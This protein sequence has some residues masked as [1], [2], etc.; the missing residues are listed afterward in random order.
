MGVTDNLSWHEKLLLHRSPLTKVRYAKTV[1]TVVLRRLRTDLD[2]MQHLFIAVTCGDTEKTGCVGLRGRSSIRISGRDMPI[3]HAVVRSFRGPKLKNLLPMETCC[4]EE[5]EICINPYHYYE[6]APERCPRID[7]GTLC[8][9]YG[10][11]NRP[12]KFADISFFK[13]P[14]K[15]EDQ[16]Y[17][18][19]FAFCDRKDLEKT[20]FLKHHRICSQ[21]FRTDDIIWTGLTPRLSLSAV[22]TERPGSSNPTKIIQPPRRLL[23]RL[24]ENG[25]H[26]FFSSKFFMKLKSAECDPV[27]NE[28]GF[29][30]LQRS[31][32]D[33]LLGKISVT[34]STPETVHHDTVLVRILP[35]AAPAFFINGVLVGNELKDYIGNETVSN[36]RSLKKLLTFRI[37]DRN[38]VIQHQC[39]VI[40]KQCDELMA[41]LS[42]DPACANYDIEAHSDP[43]EEGNE[44]DDTEVFLHNQQISSVAK[45][46]KELIVSA[47]KK[48]KQRRYSPWI[49][50]MCA[51]AKNLSAACYDFFRRVLG[52]ALPHSRTLRDHTASYDIDDGEDVEHM[53][54]LGEFCETI[55]DAYRDVNL[56]C[57]VT[58]QTQQIEYVNGRV[59]GVAENQEEV[60]PAK[61]VL[62]FIIQSIVG[63]VR[64]IVSYHFV[65]NLKGK[66]LAKILL[67]NLR[68]LAM[69]TKFR[70]RGLCSDHGAENV[71][72]RS[73]L[74]VQENVFPWKFPHPYLENEMVIIILDISHLLKR[75]WAN[76]LRA[77]NNGKLFFGDWIFDISLLQ[78]LF[79][80]E[81]CSPVKYA[82]DI[83]RKLLWPNTFEKMSTRTAEGLFSDRTVGCLT[84]LVS[85]TPFHPLLVRMAEVRGEEVTS[86]KFGL[87]IILNFIHY[88]RGFY[89]PLTT[90][91]IQQAHRFKQPLFEVITLENIDRK[92]AEMLDSL[93]GI[94]PHPQCI[95]ESLPRQTWTGLHATIHGIKE[96]SRVALER[97]AEYILPRKQCS[98]AI[99]E[100][101]A[102][103]K[104]GTTKLTAGKVRQNISN[105]EAYQ[106]L[107]ESPN[108]GSR[109]K[110]RKTMISISDAPFPKRRKKSNHQLRD[111]CFSNSEESKLLIGSEEITLEEKNMLLEQLIAKDSH[112]WICTGMLDIIHSTWESL[113]HQTEKCDRA[114]IFG[115]A[116]ADATAAL[117]RTADRNSNCE[118]CRGQ[119][120][121]IFSSSSDLPGA[122]YIGARS[123]AELSGLS[124]PRKATF[125][126]CKSAYNLFMKAVEFPEFIKSKSQ[127][128]VILKLMLIKMSLSNFHPLSDLCSCNSYVEVEYIL[129]RKT[130]N[131]LLKNYVKNKRDD[132]FDLKFG[133]KRPEKMSEQPAK[134]AKLKF[135]NTVAVCHGGDTWWLG[136]IQDIGGDHAF[137]HSDS[138]IAEA[139]WIQ[140]QDVWQLPS[141]WD[142][143]L[144]YRGVLEEDFNVF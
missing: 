120:V 40:G 101:N 73:V 29:T 34:A 59:T 25:Q 134:L 9:V 122:S 133:K 61:N 85:Q 8:V 81:R 57:D 67:R 105:I 80:L 45:F 32:N 41:T 87:E 31:D 112:L 121:D 143:D 18:A 114:D 24:A 132:L 100:L 63:N 23:N 106:E 119:L 50:R 92:F 128:A 12:N 20:G 1:I 89:Y 137:T 17:R 55:P 33:I 102:A 71:G 5:G 43:N 70:N 30:V 79:D 98:D 15:S 108:V 109:F 42:N 96:I 91:S 65:K 54:K 36:E 64:K 13:I 68:L 125:L 76:I 44:S 48:S 90:S 138:E 53:R 141:Y 37:T 140:V 93:S 46:A 27:I 52:A 49:K 77:S 94:G 69:Y 3:N 104:L 123:R 62:I 10:C 142:I 88:V 127:L 66:D 26:Q 136:Y 14:N 129:L 22:P 118:M 124:L 7:G 78:T 82:P 4:L 86:I 126:L 39:L 72:C 131:L 83:T 84:M 11:S 103:I 135:H 35:D 115:D 6:A 95:R 74:R 130:F 21:H 16:R 2:A 117:A 58:Y 56:I 116:I 28:C 97:G 60:I 111:Y 38:A 75:I 99:E 110:T 144:S 107:T 113:G 47:S 19:F 139:R 51:V